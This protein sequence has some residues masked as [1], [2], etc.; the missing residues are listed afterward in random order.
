MSKSPNSILIKQC[1]A[2]FP[3]LSKPRAFKEGNTPKY[4]VTLL[5][6]KSRDISGIK[7]AIEAA[8]VEKFGK[9]KEKWP[10]MKYPTPLRDGDEKQDTAGYKGH[11]YIKAT[12]QKAPMIIDKAREEISASEVYAGAFIN[13]GV[14]VSAYEYKEGNLTSRGVVAYLQLVQLD[15]EKKGKPFGSSVSVDDFFSD[16]DEEELEDD[17]FSD[18]SDSDDDYSEDEE[19]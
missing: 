18:D 3:S 4:E 12:S 7:K 6:P 9:N 1:R 8:K 5:I 19:D 13:A 10:K 2:S 14:N 11:W 15:N 16:E 17:D